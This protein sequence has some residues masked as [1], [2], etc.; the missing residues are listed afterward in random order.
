MT[1]RLPTGILASALIR[2]VNNAGGFATVRAKGDAQAGSMLL[3]LAERGRPIRMMERGIG[4]DGT[5][6]LLDST[7]RDDPEHY[8]RRRRASDPDLWVIELDVADAER[9]AAET[10][11]DD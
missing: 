8:W 11:L 9:F 4:P 1:G 10:I 5:T 7:P 6:T 3:M 2:R